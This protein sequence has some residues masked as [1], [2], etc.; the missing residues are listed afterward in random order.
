MRR[1]AVARGARRWAAR[2][3]RVPDL[4]AGAPGPPH[5]GRSTDPRKRGTVQTLDRLAK[6]LTALDGQGYNAYKRVKGR[7][8]APDFA[9]LVDYVQGDPFARPT[10]VRVRVDA[11]DAALP[12]WSR[13]SEPRR[14]ATADFLNRRLAQ[15]LS[16][17]RADLGS[18][19]SG[20]LVVLSPGQA[21]LTRTSLLLD[22]GGGVEARFGVGLPARGRRIRG[23]AAAELLCERVPRAVR[24]SLYA[25]ALDL[26]A[27]RRHVETV[28]DAVALRAQLA[29]AGLVAFVADGA[30]LPRRS[31]VDDG[32]LRG[33]GVV[34]FA[35]PESLRVRLDAPNAGT[36]SGMGI[37][38]GVTLIVG[39]GYHGKST[40]LHAVERGVY[41]HVPGDGRE[42][43]V[44]RPDAVKVRSED[45]RRVAGTDV[46]N[47]IATPPSGADT[48]HFRTENAS[49]STSQAAAIAEALELGC[50]CLLLDEDTSATNLMIRDARMQEL[51]PGADEP[52]TPFIDRARQLAE[53]EDVSTVLVVGG[54][55]DYFDVADTVIAMRAYVPHEVTAAAREVAGRLPTRRR[56]VDSPWKPLA[57]RVPLPAT[58]DPSRGRRAVDIKVRSL[59]RVSFGTQ[60]VDLGSLEQLVERAQTRAIAQAVAHARG[61]AIDGERALPDALARLMAEIRTGGLDVIHAEPLGDFA[62][63]RIYELAAF[64]NRLRSLEVR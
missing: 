33:E 56:S 2:P 53:E 62:E 46:S 13:A 35:S 22:A 59:D 9:L 38:T 19:R 30:S 7:W 26:D 57:Q 40:L 37:P 8:H 55:G 63:F 34:P 64:L 24:D 12:E 4:L 6:A 43:V 32:P 58:I 44:A 29:D 21:V 11:G 54:S 28:E 42:R 27:L 45:G 52:I 1:R 31:G 17:A 25:G 48:R 18:G 23:P 51:V 10:R 20:D 49:G 50:A 61:D 3:D 5:L 47:F 36:V 14:R 15:A 60:E 16:Q 39:G 41:D